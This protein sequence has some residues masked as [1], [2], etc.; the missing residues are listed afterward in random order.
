MKTNNVNKNKDR[1]FVNAF[2]VSGLPGHRIKHAP[3]P[4]YKKNEFIVDMEYLLKTNYRNSWTML[5]WNSAK[6]PKFF[7]PEQVYH[8]Y[9]TSGWHYGAN[10]LTWAAACFC[11][12]EDYLDY[13]PTESPEDYSRKQ[14]NMIGRNLEPS[15]KSMPAVVEPPFEAIREKLEKDSFLDVTD[16]PPAQNKHFLI[17]MGN[18]LYRY[19]GAGDFYSPENVYAIFLTSDWNVG[20]DYACWAMTIYC[21]KEDYL[22][23]YKEETEE[24]FLSK[25]MDML[26]SIEPGAAKLETEDMKDFVI[27]IFKKDVINYGRYRGLNGLF[28]NTTDFLGLFAASFYSLILL[29]IQDEIRLLEYFK[30]SDPYV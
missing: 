1:D 3:K 2:K 15:V 28:R 17:A 6:D 12:L 4:P 23:F 30:N 10:Y 11:T 13:F 8:I 7:S 29:K 14:K 27:Q 20:Y 26:V 22:K 5:F 21:K 25:Q 16:N 9:K 19:F 24:D 18:R